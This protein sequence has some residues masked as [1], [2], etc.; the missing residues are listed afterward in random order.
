GRFVQSQAARLIAN[1]QATAAAIQP[2]LPQGLLDVVP[3]GIDLSR[4]K[5]RQH[6]A[7]QRPLVVA[8]VGNLTTRWKNHR[9]FVRAAGLVDS[10]LPIQWRIF[11]HDP[12]RGGQ[13]E[14][15]SGLLAEAE[16]LG[17]ADR[18]QLAG[19]HSDPAEIMSQIDVLVHPAES[20]SFGRV[21]VEGMAAGL[22][23]V[24][25]A[26]GGVGEIVRHEETGLL[27]PPGDA[28]AMARYITRLVHDP[29]LRSRFGE[30]G[31]RR[32]HECYSIQAC[33]AGV[34]RSYQAAMIAGAAA[35]P[36]ALTGKTVSV[37][38]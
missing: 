36:P 20:E 31:C 4:F 14:Y 9:L 32:A 1:S 21:I 35:S 22:P 33:V 37:R 24:G 10:A 15:V 23:V 6:T 13:D 16:Q 11:G 19:F 3:N 25:V 38:G 18:F 34:I 27:A 12:S 17:L 2:W 30:A 26:A 29:D 8:M 28:E 7:G 5:P